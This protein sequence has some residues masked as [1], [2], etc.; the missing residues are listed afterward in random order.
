MIS[1]VQSF[2]S[3]VKILAKDT[4]LS[5]T[6]IIQNFIIKGGCL[7]S[8]IMGLQLCTT[9]DIDANITGITF[10]LEK[11]TDMITEIIN[12]DINDKIPF[13]LGN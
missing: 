5:H 6:Q 3:K 7:L 10:T 2:K 11:I 4:G 8:S 12:I 13:K 1:N 9:M